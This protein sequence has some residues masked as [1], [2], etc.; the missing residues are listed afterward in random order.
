LNQ[1]NSLE[2]L[3]RKYQDILI[4]FSLDNEEEKIVEI[5]LEIKQY[6]TKKWEHKFKS[7]ETK[8]VEQKAA[9][10]YSGLNLMGAPTNEI[11]MESITESIYVALGLKGNKKYKHKNNGNFIKY[12]ESL[13]LWNIL[14]GF[15]ERSA[16]YKIEGIFTLESFDPETLSL[17]DDLLEES[18]LIH[19]I[20]EETIERIRQ[21]LYSGN[22]TPEA[23]LIPYIKILQKTWKQDD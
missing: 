15:E 11:I 1:E 10:I 20:P 21:H 7:G 23:E 3:T 17:I 5:I 12:V 4:S 6:L 16:F 9:T 2:R 14:K 18:N 13:S 8:G 22:N 19:A